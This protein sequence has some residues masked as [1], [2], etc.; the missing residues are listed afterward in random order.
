MVRSSLVIACLSLVVMASKPPKYLLEESP[1]DLA[2][3]TP[4]RTEGIALAEAAVKR[5]LKDPDSA[6][7]E[8]P[9]GFVYGWYKQPFGKK[10][11]GWITCGLVNAKNGYGGYVGRAAVIVVLQSG[12]VVET[13]MDDPGATYGG[14]VARDC[15]KIGIPAA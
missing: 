1:A 2:G 6:K 9:N 13:N 8:W 7:F 3:P 11:N 14:E 15:A 5:T 10:F 12:A 4:D